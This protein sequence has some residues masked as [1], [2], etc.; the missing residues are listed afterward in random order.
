MEKL[1]IDCDFCGQHYEFDAV[2]CAQLF[3]ADVSGASEA[4][5]VRH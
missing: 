5:E 2:D 3:V 4:R 1:A